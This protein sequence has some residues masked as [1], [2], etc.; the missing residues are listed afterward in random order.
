MTHVDT[1]CDAV[2]QGIHR[3][4]SDILTNKRFLRT[5]NLRAGKSFT[6]NAKLP[7]ELP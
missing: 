6:D 4:M 3:F 2:E 5:V 7:P 1:L